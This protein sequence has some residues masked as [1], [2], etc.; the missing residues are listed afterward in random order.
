MWT[1][2]LARLF[3]GHQLSKQSADTDTS[4]W[5]CSCRSRAPSLAARST[6]TTSARP[7]PPGSSCRCVLSNQRMLRT[8]AM[9]FTRQEVS[10]TAPCT[11]PFRITRDTSLAS[12]ESRLSILSWV[13]HDSSTAQAHTCTSTSSACFP[14]AHVAAPQHTPRALQVLEAALFPV[15]AQEFCPLLG[16]V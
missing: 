12:I 3:S 16:S 14:R 7:S 2:P 1:T 9:Y 11:T 13:P 4:F 10:E 6:T 5:T 15:R 8:R